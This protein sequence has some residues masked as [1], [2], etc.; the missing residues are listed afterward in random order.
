MNEV[1][2]WFLTIMYILNIPLAVWA[3]GRPRAALT[4]NT[5]LFSMAITVFCIA[6]LLAIRP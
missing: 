1:A 5:A 3:I 4:P 6:C 2:W